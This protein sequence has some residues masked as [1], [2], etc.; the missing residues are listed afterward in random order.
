[1]RWLMVLACAAC[2]PTVCQTVEVGLFDHPRKPRP[3]AQLR[4][5]CDSKVVVEI[6]ADTVQ[7]QK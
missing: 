1:M 6:D 7:V 5:R 3:A 4:L 2:S